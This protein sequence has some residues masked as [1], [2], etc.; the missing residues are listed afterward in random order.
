MRAELIQAARTVLRDDGPQAITLQ[1]VAARVGVSHANVT[2]HFGTAAA[3]HTALIAVIVEDL[4]AATAVAV[5]HLRAGETSPR[6]VV[7]VVFDALESDGAGRLIAWLVAIGDS[8]RL[9]PFYAMIAEFVG[10]L[11][12]GDA[13][14]RA[15]GVEAIG[16]IMAAIVIPALGGALIGA[17]METVLGLQQGSVRGLV[18]DGMARLRHPS[19]A[20]GPRDASKHRE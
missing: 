18:A 13:G 2:Y 7:D 1:A 15:G 4:T 10:E 19:G 8:H 11:S 17:D 20:S 5:A 3:L 12:H 14:E 6:S 16:L 9:A